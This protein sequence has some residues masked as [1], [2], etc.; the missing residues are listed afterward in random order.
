MHMLLYWGWCCLAA[1][2]LLH[3]VLRLLCVLFGCPALHLVRVICGKERT[4][5]LNGPCISSASRL[6][7]SVTFM[8]DYV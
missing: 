4:N 2:M 5:I 1:A 6:L 8:C 3:R 7:K